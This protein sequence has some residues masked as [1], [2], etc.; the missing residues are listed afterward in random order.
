MDKDFLK[1]YNKAL[2]KTG[3]QRK[4][5]ELMGIPRSTL[6]D[7]LR[8]FTKPT[9]VS[10]SPKSPIVVRKPKQGVRR[11]IFTAAQNGTAVHQEFLAN[12]EVYA[13]FL[14]AE[15]HIARFSYNKSL[16]EQHAKDHPDNWYHPSIKKYLSDRQINIGDHVVWCGNMNTLPTATTPLSGFE[17]YT[18]GKSGVFP[19][20]KVQFVSLPRLPGEE[21]KFI[22][23]TGAVTMPNYIQKRAGIKAHFHH[24]IGA[25]LVEIDQTGDWFAR[26]LLADD[27]DGSFQDLTNLVTKGEVITDQTVEAIV[28]GDLHAEQA[29]PDILFGSFGIDGHGQVIESNSILDVLKPKYQFIHDLSDFNVRNHHNINDPHFRFK[30]HYQQRDNVNNELDIVADI[31]S[32]ISRE[33]VH[34]VIVESNHDL[35]ILRWLKEADW[36]NDP[37]NAE[38]YLEAQLAML[39]AIR[40]GDERF[41]VLEWALKRKEL[42][43]PS[44]TVQFLRENDSFRLKG[45]EFAI[46]GHLGVNGSKG[47]PRQFNKLGP[48]CVT[49]H[50]HGPGIL[51]GVY[52]VGTSSKLDMGYNKGPSTWSHTHCVLYPNGKRALITM[53][54]IK[55]RVT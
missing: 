43:A 19:H 25:L 11:F 6:K 3:S 9:F 17:T 51:D 18:R 33:N 34:T 15:I 44:G 31:L 52:A 7:R 45:I 16:Y 40:T 8:K 47:S 53:R 54:G 29:D 23:T 27:V 12:I 21:P 4:A 48:K 24:V 13:K 41:S 38:F 36:R 50:G 1:R 42:Y 55:W 10:T 28:W 14:N 30:I 37:A 46:H 2:K 26:H 35:A 49:A 22:M 5:A 39:R 20:A 32:L